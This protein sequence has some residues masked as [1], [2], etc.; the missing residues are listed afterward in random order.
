MPT[1]N[2]GLDVAGLTMMRVAADVLIEALA[3]GMDPASEPAR[4]ATKSI[5]DLTKHTPPGSLNPQIYNAALLK[6]FNKQRAQSPMMAAMRS[7]GQQQPQPGAPPGGAGGAPPPGAAPP[8]PPGGAGA[9]ASPPMPQ[10][11]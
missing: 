7:Q 1:A 8:P 6:L 3:S 4:A 11:A 5:A 2:R 9:M 10:A